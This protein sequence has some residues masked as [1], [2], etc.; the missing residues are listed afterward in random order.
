M[1]LKSQVLWSFRVHACINMFWNDWPNSRFTNDGLILVTCLHIFAGCAEHSELQKCEANSEAIGRGG[2]FIAWGGESSGAKALAQ[3]PTGGW[4]WS[5]RFRWY[6]QTELNW[7]KLLESI[8]GKGTH[9][10]IRFHFLGLFPYHTGKLCDFTS[11]FIGLM[12]V[13]F[14][15]RYN[16]SAGFVLWCWYW[17]A[18]YELPRC[19]PL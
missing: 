5:W 18:S 3:G 17:R 1:L 13:C 10:P 19:I 14:F 9:L 8:F 2:G 16:I 7:A 15:F 12:S 4:G 6:S 11:S